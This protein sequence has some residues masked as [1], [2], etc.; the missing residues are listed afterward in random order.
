MK[1]HALTCAHD[2][3]KQGKKGDVQVEMRHNEVGL[4]LRLFCPL[5][6]LQLL[7]QGMALPLQLPQR[8]FHC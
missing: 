5:C 2:I 3:V 4:L 1:T 7:Q 6:L 8:P